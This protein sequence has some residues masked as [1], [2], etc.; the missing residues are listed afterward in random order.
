LTAGFESFPILCTETL[1]DFDLPE[2]PDNRSIAPI[3][4]MITG[5]INL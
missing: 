5:F 4:K 2:H 3:E 1:K